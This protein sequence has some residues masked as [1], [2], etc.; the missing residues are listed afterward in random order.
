MQIEKNKV[1]GI[2]YTLTNDSGNKLDSSEGKDPLYFIHG[3]KNIVAGLEEALEGKTKGE[4]LNVSV[5]PEK[6]YG[7]KDEKRIQQ[8]PRSE[9]PTKEEIKPGMQFQ[10]EGPEG[11]TTVYVTKVEEETVIID[12][13]HPLAGEVLN[14]DVEIM[15]VR[16]AT[17]EELDH[18]HVH[19]AGG[20]HH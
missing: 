2:H 3:A 11:K 9:F 5:P 18:G 15:E 1:V 4:K 12:G 8:I 16:D 6:G 19:G 10:A 20:H 7:K 14:F 13:N 17:H